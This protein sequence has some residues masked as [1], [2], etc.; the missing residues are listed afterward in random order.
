MAFVRTIS[1]RVPPERTKE[2]EPGHN[3]YLASVHGIKIA[4][5]NTPGCHR[6]GVWMQRLPDGGVN[7]VMYSQ[8]YELNNIAEYSSIPMVRDFEKDVSTYLSTPVINIYEVMG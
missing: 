1:F 6:V 2:L 4:A 8:W 7:V 5:Q 3:L